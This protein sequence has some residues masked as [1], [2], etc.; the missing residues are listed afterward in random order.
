MQKRSFTRLL[1]SLFLLLFSLSVSAAGSSDF[2]SGRPVYQATPVT[3]SPRI[4][5]IGNSLTYTNDIPAMLQSLCRA[6]GINATVESVTLG[7]NSLTD[8]VNPGTGNGLNNSSPASLA[9]GKAASQQMYNKL[10]NQKWDYVILQGKSDE[11]TQIPDKMAKAV[12]TLCPL[13]KSAGAQAVLYCTWAP[14]WKSAVYDIDQQQTKIANVYYSLAKQYGCALAP[15]GIAFARERTLYPDLD[16]YISS[17][18]RL[19]PGVAGSY[20][21]ACCIYSTLF[22]KSPENINYYPAM[23]GL[24]SS[25]SQKIEQ[26]MQSLAADVALRGNLNLSGKTTFKKNG[27]TLEKGKKAQLTFAKNGYRALTYTSSNPNCISVSD[28]GEITARAYGNATITATLNNGTS[29]ICDVLVCKDSLIMGAGEK[30]AFKYD[31]SYTWSSS[32]SSV[33]TVDGQNISALKSG[34]TTL[35][36]STTNGSAISI[37]V[38]VKSAPSAL[39]VKSQ[40]I[41]LGIGKSTNL[42]AK[43]ASGT[44]LKGLTYKSKNPSIATVSKKG[45]VTARKAGKTTITIRTY[46]GMSVTCS[47]TCGTQAKKITFSNVK[48]GAKLK[49]GKSQTLKVKF[50]PSNTTIKKLKW[51][52][53]NKKVL[54][55]NKNGK[56]TAKKPGTAT[57]TATTTD[58]SKKSV[59]IKIKVVK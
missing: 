29:A 1:F 36:G 47:V 32:N 57:I 38:T 25:A 35:T 8:Y 42:K 31:S 24:S 9:A 14:D 56:I 10:K 48:S 49:V 33:A 55:V 3:N 11:T 15:S 18:D 44:S 21:S 34:C 39:M 54:T 45:V 52:S 41:F 12:A 17:G 13:I 58:G 43:I 27:Y 59:K 46:N 20:L 19:H 7:G 5:M 6:S 30:Y 50:K 23:Q 26:N 37:K 22:G 2:F 53:S 16:L 51:K 4:L 28:S 40:S